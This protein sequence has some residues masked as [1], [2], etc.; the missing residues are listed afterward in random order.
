MK[1]RHGIINKNHINEAINQYFPEDK[2]IKWEIFTLGTENTNIY[3]KFYDKE[4]VLRFWGNK[5][6]YMGKRQ[7]IDVS[8]EL[9]LMEF[10]RKYDIPIPKIYLSSKKNQYEAVNI[11]NIS[12][13]IAVFKYIDGITTQKFNET[14]IREIASNMAKMHLVAPKFTP[15]NKRR[16]PGTIIDM[17]KE[18][19]KKVEEYTR[20]YKPKS[21]SEELDIFFSLSKKFKKIL[22]ELDINTIPHAPIH[23]DIMFQNIKFKNNKLVGIFDFDNCRD[24]HFLED[25]VKFIFD[26]QF[27]LDESIKVKEEKNRDNI[28]IFLREYEK[29][30][31]FTDQEKKLIPFFFLTRLIYQLGRNFKIFFEK[32]KKIISTIPIM[33]DRYIKNKKYFNNNF[34]Y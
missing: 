23:G 25:I 1:E 19:I 30:R 34:Y 6:A 2:I 15:P 17:T 3:I 14:M 20:A 31:K 29:I 13:F 8:Y 33:I 24:S 22:S 4:I 11:N 10:F 28:N 12:R 16:Y 5:H 21:L 18:R 9:A 32:D 7:A 26:E 27:R